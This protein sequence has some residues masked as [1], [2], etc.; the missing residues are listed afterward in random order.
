MK[1]TQHLWFEKDMKAAVE[2][3]TSLVTG[4]QVHWISSLAGETPSGPDGSVKIASFALGDQRYMAIE[5]GPLDPFNHSFSIIVECETQAEIDRL[6]DALKEGG[7]TEQCGW[8]RD[9]WGLSWQITPKR[10]GELMT[11]P[12]RAKAKRV[13]QAM[14]KMVKFDIAG[15]EAAARG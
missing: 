8:L 13:T 1:V 9:R 6:W 5:A 2:F 10:L 14:L 11:D 3:Y 4:S 15:L 7:S 12:D